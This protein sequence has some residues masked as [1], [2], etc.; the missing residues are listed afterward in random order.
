[1]ILYL[2]ARPRRPLK[3]ICS[4]SRSEDYYLPRSTKTSG[5]FD[6]DHLVSRLSTGQ[7]ERIKKYGHQLGWDSQPLR[8]PVI[9]HFLSLSIC[10]VVLRTLSLYFLPLDVPFS[11]SA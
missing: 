9:D 11:F 5:P 8:H 10:S 1:M 7:Y 3:T 4:L 6:S 2:E